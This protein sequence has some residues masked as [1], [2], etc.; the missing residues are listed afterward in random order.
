MTQ[1]IHIFVA[2]KHAQ[3]V[4]QKDAR[5]RVRGQLMRGQM[6]TFEEFATARGLVLAERDNS[7]FSDAWVPLAFTFLIAGFIA[8]RNLA[9]TGPGHCA[10]AHRYG[11]QMVEDEFSCRRRL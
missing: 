3:T 10:I 7:I 2:D 9:L 11:E 1:D 4:A 5:S 8:S 6:P